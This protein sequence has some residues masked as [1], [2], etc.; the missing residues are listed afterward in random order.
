MSSVSILGS[1]VVG[2]ATGLGLLS[3]GHEV[4]FVDNNW[5]RLASLRSDG[6][7]T[8]HVD[9]M[10]LD[11]INAVFVAVPTPTG[12]HG[13]D[14]SFLEDAC[15]TIGRLLQTTT[16]AP[17]VVFRSTMPPGTTRHLIIPALEQGSGKHAGSD[18]L[19]CYNPE[20][21]RAHNAD[22]D[23]RD[24]RF[25]TCGIAEPGDAAA[26][27]MR[28]LFTAWADAVVTELSYEE[29]EFQ[30]YVHN[31][32]NATKI[33]FFNE[34]R[35]AAA[36]LGLTR[37]EAVFMLTAQTAEGS[38]NQLYGV[39]DFGPFGGACLPKDT[40]AWAAFADFYGIDSILVE[41]VRAVNISVGGRP[42]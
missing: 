26:V 19:V 27:T 7:S 4:T 42:C 39:R 12:A 15:K 5:D 35:R 9:E 28:A 14:T 37:T 41:A 2:H 8:A 17:L 29:A 33:S 1:G 13:I 30:K 11:D 34:M 16:T 31:V 32:F 10:S 21:L 36:R 20:Y 25:L 24:F 22:A 23:F 6:H 38:W 40:A 18:F 3:L